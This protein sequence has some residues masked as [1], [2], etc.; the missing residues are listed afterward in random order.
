MTG[1]MTNV[2][3]TQLLNLIEN[4]TISER[5]HAIEMLGNYPFEDIRDFL[6]ESLASHH[7]RLRA[8]CA[9]LI[10]E[11]GDNTVIFPLLQAVGDDS[12]VLRESARDALSQLPEDLFIPA[13]SGIAD[14]S[15]ANSAMIPA[16][17][18]ILAK[19][20][21]PEST[22]I[23]ISLF[24]NTSEPETIEKIAAALGKKHDEQSIKQMFHLLTHEL[25]TVRKTA[26]SALMNMPWDKIRNHLVKGL[27]NPNRFVHLST[28]EILVAR[29]SDDVLDMMDEVLR[30]DSVNAKLNAL[31]VLS[32]IESDESMSLM[33][34]VLGD[35]NPLI[36]NKA[37]L[38]LGKTR[39]KALLN[40]LQRCL[41]A[42]NETLKR[43]AIDVL[44]EIGTE[45]AVDVLEPLM[46]AD[47]NDVKLSAMKALAKTGSRRSI[48]LLLQNTSIPERAPDVLAIL[49]ELDPDLAITKIVNLLE[50]PEYFKVALK[51]LQEFDVIRVIKSLVSKINSGTPQ[52]Q[53]KAMETM[54]LLGTMEALPHIESVIYGDYSDELKQVA[55]TAKRRVLKNK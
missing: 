52:Q 34:A 35:S 30:A 37:V 27:G 18:D 38:E 15:S 28:I 1:E 41:N 16:V 8:R 4:G 13:L 6:F 17:V 26:V 46:A 44:A 51:T 36:R 21:H 40:Q 9:S 45:E 54:G 48:K 33:I 20:S 19:S 55:E 12:F 10:A 25:W 47:S 5:N 14:S 49:K 50:E 22:N 2:S 11:K 31:S 43:G 24:E 42:S 23:L 39:S 7:H 53:Q 3:L 32:G 29:S